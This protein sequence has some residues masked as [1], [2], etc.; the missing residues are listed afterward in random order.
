[1]SEKV[2]RLELIAEDCRRLALALL[3]QGKKEEALPH[4]RRAVE[5]LQNHDLPDLALAQE[6][7]VECERSEDDSD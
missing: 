3:R 7:L 6:I 5:I 4:A 2:G 1:M